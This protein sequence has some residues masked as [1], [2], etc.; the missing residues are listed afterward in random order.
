[1]RKCRIQLSFNS[2]LS[3]FYAVIGSIPK[4]DNIIIEAGTPLIKKLGIN[5]VSNI[6]QYWPGKICAD[7][8]IIDG[9]VD[10]VIMAKNA[11]AT[12]VTVM[13]SATKETLNLFVETC[14]ENNIESIVDMMNVQNPMKVLWKNNVI[15]DTVFIHRGRDEENSF[16]KII[17]YKEIAKIKGKWELQIGAAGG[18]DSREFQSAIFNNADIVVVNIVSLGSLWKGIVFDKDFESSL[19]HFLQFVK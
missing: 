5:V 11:G 15:P 12:S 7:M 6:R 18:I 10:E 16:G 3:D 9:A 4:S 2:N 14:K 1:M 17:Q 13:G 8:K 19:D